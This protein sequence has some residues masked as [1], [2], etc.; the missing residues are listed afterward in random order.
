[1]KTR[2]ISAAV[3]LVI[4]AACM[5]LPITRILF[6]TAATAMC[7]YEMLKAMR[8][9]GTVC[10][11]WTL[12][13]YIAGN[14][15]I[16]CFALRDIYYLAWLVL[17]IFLNMLCGIVSPKIGAKGALASLAVLLYPLSLFALITRFA[18][19]DA[20]P[21]VFVIACLATWTCDSFALFGGKRFGRHKLAPAV[22]PNKTIEG[23][24]CGA[25]ASAAAGII[26]FF[27]LKS[28]YEIPFWL[29][30]VTSLLS[31]SFGQVGDLAASLIKRM[32]NLKDYSNL[33]PGHG[34]MLDRADSLL[35]AI[36]TAFFCLSIAGYITI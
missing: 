8:A 12:Y 19:L 4:T 26:S 34:G 33:I 1:M 17:I 21:V 7:C 35:F 18:Y 6:F 3:L 24:L 9:I 2:V 25:A 22:S 32:A 30:I 14:A 11:A 29:C 5:F 13:L 10:T 20:W 15:V 16:A 23:T 28:A 31:S 36:P 27:I